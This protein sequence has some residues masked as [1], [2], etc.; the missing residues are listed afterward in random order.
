MHTRKLGPFT[1]SA[2]GL[3]CMSMSWGYGAADDV[4]S[5][6]LLQEALDAGY[7]FLD[8]A[9][10]YGMG[11]NEALIGRTLSH[12]RD[13]FVLASK[14]GIARGEDGN[15]SVDGRPAILKQTC[16]KSLQLLQT[17]VIDLY[18]LHRLD[19]RVPVEESVGALA[20]LVA[21]GKVRSLGLSEVSS[22]TLRRAHAVHPITAVQSEYS[23]WVRTPERRMLATCR[24][25]GVSFVPF[26]PL[27]R[28][29]LTGCARDVTNLEEGDIRTNVA[30]PR[31]EPENF[32]ANQQLLEPFGESA[33]EQGCS[34]AQLAIAWVL[35][36]EDG[37]LVPIPG[38]K[39]IEYMRE[40]AAAGDI[41]LEPAVVER[42][43]GLINDRTV[44]G[45][46]YNAQ[47]M[48]SIDSEK[49]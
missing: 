48:A 19:P 45:A 3:G 41:R 25:L 46:R 28:G 33:R 26:S 12:R 39:H 31:F 1:V 35:A 6:Q 4:T 38:T 21:E 44:K 49:D 42:L 47:L 22:E 24:E 15:L 2:V 9:A 36:R 29:F 8:T 16:E 32:A 34:M 17:D 20:E 30:R 5:E 13:E 7:S 37:T 43:D 10:M 40:N 23:L 11:H 27:G 14:C 18:Y